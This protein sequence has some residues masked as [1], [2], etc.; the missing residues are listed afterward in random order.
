M[1]R[2]H[3]LGNIFNR[4]LLLIFGGAI[5]ACAAIFSLVLQRNAEAE[6]A[7]K[8]LLFLDSM[9]AVRNYTSNQVKPLLEPQLGEQFL[10]QAIAAY[11]AR[12]VF[13]SLHAKKEYADLTYK[14]ATLNPFNPANQADGFEADLLE[15]FRTEPANKQLSGFHTREGAEVFYVARPLVVTQPSCLACHGDPQKAPASLID[16]Y[17]SEHGFG[18]KLGQTV[19]VHI[20]SVPAGVPIA[21][22][23]QSFF[24]FIGIAAVVLAAVIVA[25]N[26]LLKRTVLRPLSQMTAAAEQISKGRLDFEMESTASFEM[27]ALAAAF[28]RMKR[29]VVRSMRLLQS[30]HYDRGRALLAAGDLDGAIQELYNVLNVDP[31]CVA[32]RVDLAR[33]LVRQ[34]RSQ[35]AI[36]QYNEAL[37]L[38]PEDPHIH[39]E[40]GAL[41]LEQGEQA[42]GLNSR[43]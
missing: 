20:V 18:W 9:N 7:S 42:V 23:R 2:T 32:A 14:Q 10:P 31:D 33:A 25:I 37:R 16:R 38:A 28:E 11:S 12:S 41:L 8:A 5:V 13:E 39:L 4:I 15:R 40:L 17:G 26:L 3:R 43:S 36:A 34:G 22:A 27:K 29:S 6:L 1:A 21:T 24:W 30:V 19:G 35:E